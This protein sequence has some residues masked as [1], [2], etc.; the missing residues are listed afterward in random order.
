MDDWIVPRSITMIR[1]NL[2]IALDGASVNIAAATLRRLASLM[3]EVDVK[4]HNE[5]PPH[6]RSVDGVVRVQ[7]GVV[8]LTY[9]R[10]V[11]NQ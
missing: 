3:E 2:C 9:E 8:D 10:N 5:N 6:F 11:V 4:I 1:V 7:D